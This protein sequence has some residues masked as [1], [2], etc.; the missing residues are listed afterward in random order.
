MPATVFGAL[1]K[2]SE[3]AL[4]PTIRFAKSGMPPKGCTGFAVRLTPRTT[5]A[6]VTW[7]AGVML[8]TAARLT[9]A[10][11]LL[12]IGPPPGLDRAEVRTSG[13][14]GNRP[15]R[16]RHTDVKRPPRGDDGFMTAVTHR[17]ARDWDTLEP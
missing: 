9:A 7:P 8:A 5:S 2:P 16:I 17:E 11:R 4:Y 10:G 15:G 13:P 1:V 6:A 12:A 3:N 14:A